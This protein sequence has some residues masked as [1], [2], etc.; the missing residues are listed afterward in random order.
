MGKLTKTFSVSML[1]LFVALTACRKRED[2]NVQIDYLAPDR[3]WNVALVATQGV[4]N[5]E[6]IAPMDVFHH[7]RFHVDPAMNVFIVSPDTV[8]ITSFEG[9]TIRPDYSFDDP[10]M[11]EIDVLVVPSAEHSMDDDLT[12][13]SLIRFVSTRGRKAKYVMSLCDGAFVLAR[14]G[15]VEGHLSTTFPG[16][17]NT[18]RQRFPELEVKENVSFV[19]DHNLITSAGGA[20][21]Y[22]AALYLCEL[23]YGH[24][25]ARSIGQG[26]VIDWDLR[27]VSYE[28]VE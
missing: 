16:D 21:S 13:E 22:E 19:H 26:L 14:A 27:T 5:S 7:I 10:A 9:L 8:W 3:Q 4:Y 12:N 18:Y 15:L 1:I 6:L 17:V 24:E 11:P 23:L 25:I 28:S 2:R 20:R